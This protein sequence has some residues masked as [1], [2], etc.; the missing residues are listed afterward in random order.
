[1]LAYLLC[2]RT[3]TR[4]ALVIVRTLTLTNPVPLL[5]H[6]AS[7]N[8]QKSA[9]AALVPGMAMIFTTHFILEFTFDVSSCTKYRPR[10]TCASYNSQKFYAI[11]VLL[12]APPV[13]I[14]VRPND[15]VKFTAADDVS[16]FVPCCPRAGSRSAS[17]QVLLPTKSTP[18]PVHCSQRSRSSSISRGIRPVPLAW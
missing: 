2:K 13:P 18:N 7:P 16:H 12:S 17:C 15:D 4:L 8:M 9:I 10:A 3:P 14:P 6:A 1:M 5:S 11:L